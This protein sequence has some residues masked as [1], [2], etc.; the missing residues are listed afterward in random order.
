LKRHL[1]TDAANDPLGGDLTAS[2]A[3]MQWALLRGRSD[4]APSAAGVIPRQRLF[5]MLEE[6]MAHPLGE[7]SGTDRSTDSARAWYI[8][9]PAG[10]GKSTLALTWIEHCDALQKC[11]WL[12]FRDED[13]ADPSRVLALLEAALLERD[14]FLALRH[15]LVTEPQ[16]SATDRIWALSHALE[17]Q[18]KRQILVLDHMERML[19]PSLA[20]LFLQLLVTA[21]G[22]LDLVFISRR[23]PT[24]SLEA[25][26]QLAFLDSQDLAL[27]LDEARQMLAKSAASITS[28]PM[29]EEIRRECDGWVQPVRLFALHARRYGSLVS[30]LADVPA[31]GRFIREGVFDRLEPAEQRAL[32]CLADA[33]VLSDDVIGAILSREP[34]AVTPD[35][36]PSAGSLDSES[37]AARA[38]RTDR[39]PSAVRLNRE[40]LV[41]LSVPVE[42]STG[43][44][45]WFR[46]NGLLR[47]WLLRQPR[48]GVNERR[49]FLSQ[50][51][52]DRGDRISAV[53]YAAGAGDREQAVEIASACSESLLLSH[54]VDALAKLRPT[55]TDETIAASPRLRLVYAWVHAVGGQFTLARALID[56]MTGL[57]AASSARHTALEAFIACGEGDTTRSE[58]AAREAL[59]HQELLSPQARV[60][61]LLV[62]SSVARARKQFSGARDWNRQAASTARYAA[63]FACES[64]SAYDHSRIELSKGNLTRAMQLLQSALE[65]FQ[66]QAGGSATASRSRLFLTQALIAW[67]RGDWDLADRLLAQGLPEAER[68]RDPAA[69]L[70]FCVRAMLHQAYGRT[71]DAFVAVGQAERQM[72]HWR[73]D[74]AN[75]RPVLDL[76]K[77]VLWLEDADSARARS[78]LVLL[79][80]SRNERAPELFPMLPDLQQVLCIRARLKAGDTDG[81]LHELAKLQRSQKHLPP[82]AG[83]KLYAMLLEAYGTASKGAEDK[84]LRLLKEALEL[85]AE[86]YYIGPFIELQQELAPLLRRILGAE[87]HSTETGFLQLLRQ[88]LRIDLSPPAVASTPPGEAISERELAVLELIAQGLS[89]QQIGDRLHISLHTVKTHA[90]KINVKLGVRSRTQAIVRARALGYL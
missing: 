64:L 18:D 24:A 46:L 51:F 55:L 36:K 88:R 49:L 25:T 57:D 43:Q 68:V 62:L 67:F 71:H 39:E 35:R 1:N 42:F 29:L 38:D 2:P 33:E 58:A 27:T 73:I 44:G 11:R 70:G 48:E 54:N 17:Q 20:P 12:S 77:I 21:P 10:T 9:G 80:T 45:A 79:E 69:L 53:H 23:P 40:S 7:H 86:E 52:A 6:R 78:L 85:A 50:W 76:L 14:A 47:S 22:T 59:A 56:N 28:E 66:L 61:V 31:I 83:K 19:V 37:A 4:P 87:D 60:M 89:N 82:L 8:W 13:A 90:R 30:S 81:A 15:R 65:Q 74:T 72:Q 16:L 75:Y 26:G 3:P 41:E 84:A 32:S 5:R 63:D 34:A